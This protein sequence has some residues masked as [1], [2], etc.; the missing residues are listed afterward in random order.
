ME[1]NK[2]QHIQ[3]KWKLGRKKNENL[4]I[5]LYFLL[6][7]TNE[8]LYFTAIE[9]IKLITKQKKINYKLW[10]EKERKKQ[11]N[12]LCLLCKIGKQLAARRFRRQNPRICFIALF[13]THWTRVTFHIPFAQTLFLSRTKKYI[14]IF[15]FRTNI[16]QLI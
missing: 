2:I 1:I 9:S 13:A 14:Y 16:K 8:N 4:Y 10:I 12:L 5:F 11:Q 3:F 7:F 15:C 6:I